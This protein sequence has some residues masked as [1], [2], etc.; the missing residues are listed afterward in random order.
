MES[1][2]NL[3]KGGSETWNY[4]GIFFGDY[5]RKMF[6]TKQCLKS[7]SALKIIPAS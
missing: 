6:A 2:D 7:G 3:V 4:H 5:L 1:M